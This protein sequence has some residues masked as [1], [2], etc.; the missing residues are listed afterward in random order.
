[1]NVLQEWGESPTRRE[2]VLRLNVFLNRYADACFEDE[3]AERV[4]SLTIPAFAI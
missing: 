2:M 3:K 4:R 1:M